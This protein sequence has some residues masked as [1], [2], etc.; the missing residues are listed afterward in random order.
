MKILNSIQVLFLLFVGC[1]SH[2]QGVMSVND[3]KVAAEAAVDAVSVSDARKMISDEA[4]V[5]V[6]VREEDEIERLGKIE[7]AV[8]VPR[9]VLEF[10]IDPTSSLHLSTFS[11]GK[12]IIFYCA[13]G[14]RSLLAAKLAKDMGLQEPLYLDGGYKKWIEDSAD[15]IQ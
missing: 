15:S 10:Y 3:Y 5:F 6:D 11:S 1:A 13:T 12:Q 14:G 9:G 4:V 2:A 7:D 8:H